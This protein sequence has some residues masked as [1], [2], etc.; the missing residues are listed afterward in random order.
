MPSVAPFPLQGD[1]V[2]R[3]V[4]TAT[5]KLVLNA[6]GTPWL[7]FDLDADPLEMCNLAADPKRGREMAELSPP[8]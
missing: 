8:A 3:G 1:R 7:F 4:R 5:R 6:D 2:W